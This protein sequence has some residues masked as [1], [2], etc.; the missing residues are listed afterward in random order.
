VRA[1]ALVS[2]L[3]CDA[4]SPLHTRRSPVTVLEIARRARAGLAP[5]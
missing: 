4:A 3:V 1:L 5:G 2:F